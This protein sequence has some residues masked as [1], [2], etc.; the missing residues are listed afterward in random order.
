MTVYTVTLELPGEIYQQAE[1]IARATQRPVEQVV[2]E[3]IHPPQTEKAEI[4]TALE[5]LSNE[6]LIQAARASVLPDSSRRL[7]ELLA[8]QEQRT[9]T[10]SEQYEAAT[11]VE[12]ED[13]LTLRKAKALFLLKQRGILPD[14][15]TRF[16]G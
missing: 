10:E 2:V 14:D 3:W 1:Q 7:Q 11:L 15:L 4:L 6:Q 8:V 16:L 9:L 5:N 13:L 12:Q